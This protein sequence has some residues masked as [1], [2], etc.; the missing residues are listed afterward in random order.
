M[1]VRVPH[2]LSIFKPF[3]EPVMAAVLKNQS[4]LSKAFKSREKKQKKHAKHLSNVQHRAALQ[5]EKATKSNPGDVA[6]LQVKID[7]ISHGLHL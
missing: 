7:A 3:M 2:T 5:A 1:W 4:I 6:A